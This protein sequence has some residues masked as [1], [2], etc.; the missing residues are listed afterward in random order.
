M[1]NRP[2]WE[3]EALREKAQSVRK[4]PRP[5]DPEKLLTLQS[6]RLLLHRT[7]EMVDGYFALGG[8]FFSKE[9]AFAEQMTV[10]RNAAKKKERA[11][12]VCALP[13]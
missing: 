1:Q 2:C 9:N 4:W 11:G 3:L 6:R 5:D 10:W 12:G 7:E 8:D 13:P